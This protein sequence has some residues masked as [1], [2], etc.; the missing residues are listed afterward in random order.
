MKLE[1][2]LDLAYAPTLD[3]YVGISSDR[4]QGDRVDGGS[5]VPNCKC[6]FSTW[7]LPE[8]VSIAN[9]GHNLLCRVALGYEGEN[10]KRRRSRWDLTCASHVLVYREENET[11]GARRAGTRCLSRLHE[12]RDLSSVV[13]IV[14]SDR[15]SGTCLPF[16]LPIGMDCL[17]AR[18]DT[19]SMVAAAAY[20]KS[21]WSWDLHPGPTKMNRRQRHQPAGRAGLACEGDVT[22]GSLMVTRILGLPKMS[23]FVRATGSEGTVFT[24][25]ESEEPALNFET[26]ICCS[27]RV[28]PTYGA[29]LCRLYFW[30]RGTP[31]VWRGD[32]PSI[33]MHLCLRKETTIWPRGA[34][35]RGAVRMSRTFKSHKCSS[36]VRGRA[37]HSLL[38]STAGMRRQ[39]CNAYVVAV[40]A[41]VSDLCE[42]A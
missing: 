13:F 29:I 15:T 28:H 4:G 7:L 24:Q 39:Q 12:E 2:A 34:V 32:G 11:V 1:K 18:G 19:E 17:R 16:V 14:C 9:M 8:Q 5:D 40:V 10:G 25:P 30:P 42:Q 27:G 20:V 3:D 35:K 37:S 31:L 6:S 33:Y 38:V 26:S 21:L 23:Y 22:K 36:Y 41:I